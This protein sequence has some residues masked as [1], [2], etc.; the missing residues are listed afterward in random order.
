M[1][2]MATFKDYLQKDRAIFIN[3]DEFGG[4]G[5]V[6]G[7]QMPMMIDNDRL[8]ERSKIEYAGVEV[9]E[10]LYFAFTESF[11]KAPKVGDVQDFKGEDIATGEV[12]EGLYEVFDVRRDAGIYEI[13]LRGCES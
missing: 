13:I 12:F 6:N 5:V 8:K 4:L 2:L 3:L 1:R 7:V 11:T 9:G 10:L